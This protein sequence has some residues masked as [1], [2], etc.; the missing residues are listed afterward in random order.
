MNFCS[1]CITFHKLCL[2]IL[3]DSST[4][5]FH[6]EIYSITKIKIYEINY[7]SKNIFLTTFVGNYN[8]VLTAVLCVLLMGFYD[9]VM[10]EG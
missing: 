2:K 4:L 8:V 6:L 7:N 5:F 9:Y 1:V 10:I 3:I